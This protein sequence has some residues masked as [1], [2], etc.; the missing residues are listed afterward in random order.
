MITVRSKHCLR[1]DAS[2]ITIRV[3]T[4]GW[5]STQTGPFS[6]ALISSRSYFDISGSTIPTVEYPTFVPSCLIDQ[7][8]QVLFVNFSEGS[9]SFNS[10]LLL[11]FC[12]STKS[13][14]VKMEFRSD[15]FPLWVGNE[16]EGGRS[17]SSLRTN[18]TDVK[19]DV[20]LFMTTPT[21]QKFSDAR[22]MGG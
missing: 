8:L 22:A 13:T 18:W 10:T 1:K 9:S 3:F 12:S 17:I 21:R 5:D 4:G 11:L 7:P 16:L 19:I 15:W 6:S 20:F 2:Q 14:R